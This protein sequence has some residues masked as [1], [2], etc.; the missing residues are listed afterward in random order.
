MSTSEYARIHG[1]T[2]ALIRHHRRGDD[3]AAALILEQIDT[4]D[5]AGATIASLL[6]V[7]DLF[8]DRTPGADDLLAD[9]SLRL[10][11]DND[12]G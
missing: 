6:K 4:P 7:V 3:E 10:A 9:L 11:A 8:A 1:R 5:K 12:Q 2:V